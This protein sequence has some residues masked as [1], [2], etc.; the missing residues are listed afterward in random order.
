MFQ[1]WT[2][3]EVKSFSVLMDDTDEDYS[4]SES[5][6]DQREDTIVQ[7]CII[8]DSDSSRSYQKPKRKKSSMNLDEFSY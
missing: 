3:L 4:K 7:D 8:E 1:E 6:I 2:Q 5:T